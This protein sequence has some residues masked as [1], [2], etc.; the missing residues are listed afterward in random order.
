[1]KIKNE[2]IV[3]KNG[4]K[5]IE[6]TNLILN[7]YLKQFVNAQKSTE[8]MRKVYNLKSLKYCLLKFDTNLQFD[9]TSELNNNVF[10]VC[11]VSDVVINQEGNE[12][13]V[14]I[15][16]DY[17]FTTKPFLYVYSRGEATQDISQFYGRKITAIAFNTYFLPTQVPVC[18]ILDTSNYNIYLQEN[19]GFCITRKDIVST[20]A[21]FWSSTS[22]LK[23]PLHIA[24]NNIE[25]IFDNRKLQQNY[26]AWYPRAFPILYSVGLSSNINKIE[27]EF[28]IGT[29]ISMQTDGTEILLS[30]INNR[31]SIAR[32]FLPNFLKF[33]L[34]R[35]SY[36]YLIIKYKIYQV[37]HTYTNN[38]TLSENI[39]TGYYYHLAIPYGNAGNKKTIIK[40]E[41]G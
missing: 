18:A 30:E 4:N 26:Q 20:D 33:Y 2:S 13:Q 41:R 28:V 36:K 12:K 35:S 19:Q 1:M 21:L 37:L 15:Q 22:K 17:D 29:D 14:S 9:E 38:D 5:K 23:Y 39:D 34:T 32:T 31:K 10:D 40:Y 24:P 27:E 16:Y 7:S 3:I 25:A 8:E 11:L 6:V